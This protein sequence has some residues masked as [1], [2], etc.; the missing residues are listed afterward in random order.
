ML[1]LTRKPGESII[2]ADNI[3][4]T[5]VDIGQGRVRLGIEAPDSMMIDREEIH[6]R[7]VAEA[8]T[9]QVMEVAANGSL[10]NRIS[11]L[12]LPPSARRLPHKSR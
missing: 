8:A 6:E 12:P 4:I 3:R 10:H 2:I 7:R 11:G 9:P 5:V 1:V